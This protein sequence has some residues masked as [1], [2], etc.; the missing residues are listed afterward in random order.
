MFQSILEKYRI[1]Y[2]G[3]GNMPS[4]ADQMVEKLN[5]IFRILYSEHGVTIEDGRIEG[6][7]AA[8]LGDWYDSMTVAGL[9][10]STRNNY[11]A[12]LNPFL[13]WGV[14]RRV[15]MKDPEDEEPIYK[16]LTMKRLPKEEEIPIE[17][18]KP[19][20]LTEEQVRL[21]MNEM[22]GKNKKRDRAIL[23]LFLASGIR[24][25]ELCSLNLSSVLDQPHGLIYLKRKG[26]AWKHTEVAEFFYKYL[27]I[28]LEGRDLSDRS[29]P[30]FLTT[31]NTRCNRRQI[32]KTFSD[33]EHLL[34]LPTGM[35]ILRHTTLS[36]L[37]K[38]GGASI[39]RDVANHSSFS[40][41]N[42]YTHTTSEERS[43][44]INHLDWCDL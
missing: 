29:Q 30:L 31:Q 27:D 40:M 9:K 26:G 18:R 6:L 3:E 20:A 4:T 44:A 15:I 43:A 19:K 36:N 5:R 21:L 7:N 25:S 34:G 23:A 2:L 17:Q 32:L 35:H 14:Q 42:R 38:K 12:L 13:H 39:T 16:V 22:P 28:Y 11:V 8:V 24:V 37:E 33:K 41:T 10:V 1:T